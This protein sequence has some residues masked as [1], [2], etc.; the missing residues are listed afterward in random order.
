MTDTP[1]DPEEVSAADADL[2]AALQHRDAEIQ[3]R[4]ELAREM[5][6]LVERAERLLERSRGARLPIAGAPPPI[7]Q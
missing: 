1:P 4:E 2:R 7:D 6:A 3:R 5:E